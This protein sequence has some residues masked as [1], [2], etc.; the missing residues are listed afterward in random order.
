MK[1][2]KHDGSMMTLDINGDVKAEKGLFSYGYTICFGLNDD[3][4]ANNNTN[5]TDVRKILKEYFD[6]TYQGH[7]IDFATYSHAGFIAQ[8]RLFLKE[9]LHRQKPKD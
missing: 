9:P 6:G 1:I 3:G 5:R 7:K 4:S 2:L 8:G